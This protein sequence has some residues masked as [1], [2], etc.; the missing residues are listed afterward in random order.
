ML[1]LCCSLAHLNTNF[2]RSLISSVLAAM[3]LLFGVVPELSWQAP[4]L[5]FTFSAYTQ[6]FS[7]VQVTNYARAV[8]AIEAYRQRAYHNIQKIIGQ[9]PPEIVCDRR[10]TLRNL[11]TEAQKV[12]VDYC[13]TSKK[14]VENS[15][16]SVSQFNNITLRVRSDQ[17]LKRRIQNAMIRIRQQK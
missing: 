5:S 17:E 15:G 16:L 3:G 7:D 14:V 10:E 9:S 8:L 4:R 12:A 6:D 11:P 1:I 13:N 2:T